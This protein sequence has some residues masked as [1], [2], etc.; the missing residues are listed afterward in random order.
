MVSAATKRIVA[1]PDIKPR[2]Y[3]IEVT[4]EYLT[5]KNYL[6]NNP[7]KTNTYYFISGYFTLKINTLFINV[8]KIVQ[9]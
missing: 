2:Q 8:L 9:K 5:H 7:I 1:F 4:K 6:P 3:P